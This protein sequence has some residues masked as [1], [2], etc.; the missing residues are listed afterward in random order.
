MEFPSN[1]KMD[2]TKKNAKPEVLKVISGDA[3]Q[4]KKTLKRR[5]KEVF[6]GADIKGAS[7]YIVVDVLYPAMRNMIV[8]ATT[9]GVE[10]FVYG[11]TRPRSRSGQHRQRTSYNTPVNRG[12]RSMMLPD[13]PPHRTS[14]PIRPLSDDIVISTYEDAEQ[15]LSGLC[16]LID[17]YEMVTVADFKALLGMPSAFVDHKWGWTDLTNVSTTQIR[18]GYLLNLPNPEPLE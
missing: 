9:K 1:S 14:Q 6:V 17:D 15:A 16:E 11:D 5:F 18:D 2:N 12:G 4:Q 10:R 13:Q 7:S 8:D 3:V